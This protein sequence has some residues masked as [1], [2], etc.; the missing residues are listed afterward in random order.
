[1]LKQQ[2]ATHNCTGA[3]TGEYCTVTAEAG[4]NGF[5]QRW[6][7]FFQE[8]IPATFRENRPNDQF[9]LTIYFQ[10][11][12]STWRGV[13]KGY[14][15]KRMKLTKRNLDPIFFGV[16]KTM[17]FKFAHLSRD[18]FELL[19]LEPKDSDTPTKYPPQK[20]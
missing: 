6:S 8:T 10:V 9:C 4:E 19:R 15:R 18:I 16:K 12:S 2:G 5:R 20:S 3:V 1:M 7:G 13:R 17:I 11:G 14:P